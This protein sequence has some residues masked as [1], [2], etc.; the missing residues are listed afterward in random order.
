[1][2]WCVGGE[3]VWGVV[4]GLGRSGVRGLGW[5]GVWDCMWGWGG[6]VCGGGGVLESNSG[7]CPD[8]LGLS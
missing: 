5:G 8:Y 2:G 7:D 4:C 1:M 3:M 6:V